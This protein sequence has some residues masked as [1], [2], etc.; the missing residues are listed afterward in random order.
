MDNQ[1]PPFPKEQLSR[2]QYREQL[3]KKELLDRKKKA[4]GKPASTT[5]KTRRDKTVKKKQLS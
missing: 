5:R 4:K 1:K 2:K 3:A